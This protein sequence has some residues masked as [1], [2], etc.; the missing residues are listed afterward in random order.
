M[1]DQGNIYSEDPKIPMENF[2]V[3]LSIVLYDS[4]LAQWHGAVFSKYGID[5]TVMS[6]TENRY[7]GEVFIFFG[8]LFC[9]FH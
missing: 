7:Y 9:N 3:M 6:I 5:R 1:K 2:T 8:F 4:P